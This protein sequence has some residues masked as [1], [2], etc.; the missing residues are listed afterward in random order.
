MKAHDVRRID[1]QFGGFRQVWYVRPNG[2]FHGPY[3]VYW[4]E[5]PQVCMHGSYL[6]GAQEGV[7]TYWSRTGVVERQVRFEADR[8]VEVRESPPW[9]VE[10]PV[11]PAP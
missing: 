7:W 10:L 5:G 2:T 3:T 9:L 11:I 1:K 6:D 8:E 4:D